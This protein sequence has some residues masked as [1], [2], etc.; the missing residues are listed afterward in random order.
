MSLSPSPVAQ[1]VPITID[2]LT[3]DADARA[4]RELN[5]EWI[6][7]LFTLEAADSATLDDPV[8]AIVDRGGQ[9]LIA[10]LGD[11]RIGCVALVPTGD[12]VFELSKMAVQP[13]LRG[14]GVGRQ[15]I[16][17]AIILAGRLGATSLFLGSSTK[18]P[19]AVHLYES[20][21]FTHVPAERIRPMPYARADVFMELPLTNA[22]SPANV[23]KTPDPRNLSPVGGHRE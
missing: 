11:E 21:G 12:G 23:Q 14:K 19:N 9:V 15:L 2:P 6:R 17:A 18:L 20:V 5:E 10:R 22:G 8:G 3:S 7:R 1:P 16:T 13:G 4:F